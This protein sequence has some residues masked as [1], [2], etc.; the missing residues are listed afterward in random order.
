MFSQVAYFYITATMFEYQ[1]L[2][3]IICMEYQVSLTLKAD[4]PSVTYDTATA[5]V[6]VTRGVKAWNT[7]CSVTSQDN[8]IKRKLQILM[9]EIKYFKIMA[10]WKR[11]STEKENLFAM[12]K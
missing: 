11:I 6:T 4:L 9:V 8:R 1:F 12:T 5:K 10:R 2:L 3:K 7:T